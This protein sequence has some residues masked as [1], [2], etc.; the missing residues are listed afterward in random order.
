[1]DGFRKEEMQKAHNLLKETIRR[2]EDI[3]KNFPGPHSTMIKKYNKDLEAI[4]RDLN[5]IHDTL[6]FVR[7]DLEEKDFKD[8]I[9]L[10]IT[11]FIIFCETNVIPLMSSVIL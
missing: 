11:K 6:H 8:K 9:D 5:D 1:M 2:M 3:N 7:A 10:Y 4:I